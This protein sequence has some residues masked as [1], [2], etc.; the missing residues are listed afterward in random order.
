[1]NRFWVGAL[2]LGS[3]CL[4]TASF[5]MEAQTTKLVIWRGGEDIAGEEFIAANE[6]IVDYLATLRHPTQGFQ[7]AD[8]HCSVKSRRIYPSVLPY[9]SSQTGTQQQYTTVNMVYELKDCV[10]ILA[11]P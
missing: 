3:L 11:Q 9:N 6:T 8:Y 1:M 2:A 5:G 10:E 4:G 7:H